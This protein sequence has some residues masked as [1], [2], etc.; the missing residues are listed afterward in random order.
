MPEWEDVLKVVGP[1][2]GAVVAYSLNRLF[3]RP[4]AN[5]KT[6]LELLTLLEGDEVSKQREALR[7]SV[8]AQIERIYCHTPAQGKNY[9]LF[10][11]GLVW[12]LAFVAATFFVFGSANWNN[13][14]AVLTVWMSLAG[15]GWMIAG[16]EGKVGRSRKESATVS[17]EIPSSL[18]PQVRELVARHRESDGGSAAP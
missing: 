7:N 5:L 10:V 15:L 8:V 14:W 1:V 12:A 11:F 9:G 13:W 3:V 16:W 17:E 2:L 18:L 6:D 4:R